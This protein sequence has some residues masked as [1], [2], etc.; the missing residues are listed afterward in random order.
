MCFEKVFA[1]Y[2]GV[3]L[4]REVMRVLVLGVWRIKKAIYNAKEHVVAVS[5][6]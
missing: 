5:S 6:G 1:A 4:Q 2:S 3:V